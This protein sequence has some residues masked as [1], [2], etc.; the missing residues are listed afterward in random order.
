MFMKDNRK[1]ILM[2]LLVILIGQPLGLSASQIGSELLE[3][4]EIETVDGEEQ[5][6]TS[7]HK[8]I[9]REIISEESESTV[10]SNSSSEEINSSETLQKSNQEKPTISGVNDKTVNYGSKFDALSGVTAR[11]END[12]NI[13][14]MIEISGDKVNTKNG[15]G[16]YQLTYTVTDPTNPNLVTQVKRTITVGTTKEYFTSSGIYTCDYYKGTHREKTIFY[17]GKKC[18]EK[19]VK[20]EIF[21]HAN[22]KMKSRKRFNESMGQTSYETWAS[23]GNRTITKKYNGKGFKTTEYRF[24]PNGK[25]EAKLTYYQKGISKYQKNDYNTE[26]KLIK[27]SRYYRSNKVQY[28]KEFFTNGK[29]KK[30]SYYNT[31]S[32]YTSVI[33]WNSRGVRTSTKEYNGKGFKTSEYTYHPNGKIKARYTYYKTG[34]AMYTRVDYNQKGEKTAYTK[35]D[36][37]KNKLLKNTYFKNGKVSKSYQEHIAKN[38]VKTGITEQWYYS[39]G[40]LKKVDARTFPTYYSQYTPYYKK[41]SCPAYNG[42]MY[43]HGCIMNSMSM[44]YL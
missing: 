5:S 37:K 27:E 18:D 24:H 44:F 43:K 21:Y 14:A 25:I 22:G 36:R 19:R 34:A 30:A 1:K 2:I 39:S 4:S 41:F 32:Q 26:G 11:D 8:T 20:E 40:K 16:K 15:G 17:Y 7:A 13:T 12:Q 28:R 35:Y 6:A 23:N 31:K 42:N 3:I 9:D 38:G 10:K 33:K 29:I